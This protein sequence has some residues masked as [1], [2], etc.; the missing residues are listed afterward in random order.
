V[1]AGLLCQ[2]S[3]YVEVAVLLQEMAP[4]LASADRVSGEVDVASAARLSKRVS[5]MARVLLGKVSGP[6][7]GDPIR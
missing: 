1:S 5:T 3:L 7:E 2:P 6:G 4:V